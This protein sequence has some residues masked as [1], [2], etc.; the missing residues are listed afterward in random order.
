MPQNIN[1]LINRDALPPIFLRHL[2]NNILQHLRTVLRIFQRNIFSLY[3]HLKLRLPKKWQRLMIEHVHRKAHSPN[4]R[5]PA[6]IA[7]AACELMLRP[8]ETRSSC[9]KIGNVVVVAISHSG[10]VND[11]NLIANIGGF[12][13]KDIV[14][15][16]VP[17]GDSLVM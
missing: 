13:A 8:S 1:C 3:V 5:R 17:I 4:I 10:K 9:W 2:L 15:L 12:S 11:L 16:H 6:R 7:I 14:D